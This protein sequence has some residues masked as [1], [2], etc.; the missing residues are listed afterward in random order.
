MPLPWVRLDTAMP[1]NPK[2]LHL[3]ESHKEGRAAAF[4]W[5]CGLAYSGKHGTDGFITRS[6][7]SRINGL[8]VHA[9]LLVEHQLWKDEGVGWTVPGWDEFQESNT[10]T[11]TRSDRARKAAFARWH[12]EI[13]NESQEA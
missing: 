1:D 8:A 4:V 13:D 2:I 6:A 10:E 7:L 11:K 3:I 12:K 9:H 5:L